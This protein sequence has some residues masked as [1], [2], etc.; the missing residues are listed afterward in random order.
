M[1]DTYPVFIGSLPGDIT[2]EEIDNL[3]NSYG[4]KNYK[5]KKKDKKFRKRFVVLIFFS[6]EDYKAILGMEIRYRGYDLKIMP[7][8]SGDQKKNLDE[9]IKSRRIYFTT[10]FRGLN[11]SLIERIF[12]RYGKLESA[13]MKKGF[14]NAKFRYGFVTYADKEEA[15]KLVEKEVFLYKGVEFLVKPFRQSRIYDSVRRKMEKEQRN[16]QRMS[17]GAH[18]RLGDQ[19]YSRNIA[20]NR[21]NR[22]PKNNRN[23]SD[24]NEYSTFMF[25]KKKTPSHH[26]GPFGA[27]MENL[28]Y[29]YGQGTTQNQ[30]NF[31]SNPKSN[32]TGAQPGFQ[33]F[34][35]HTS[36]HGG[37]YVLGYDQL[38]SFNFTSPQAPDQQDQGGSQR[39]EYREQLN[40]NPRSR[41]QSQAPLQ[42][43][44][45]TL[46][47][48]Q[49][50]NS[51]YFTDPPNSYQNEPDETWIANRPQ[52]EFPQGGLN[53]SIEAWNQ[54]QQNFNY[55][56]TRQIQESQSNFFNQNKIDESKGVFRNEAQGFYS[57][58]PQSNQ[59]G[60]NRLHNEPFGLR[61]GATNLNT[62]EESYIA[63]Q[64]Q[65]R[66]LRPLAESSESNRMVSVQ[67]VGDLRESPLGV[68]HQEQGMRTESQE[69]SRIPDLFCDREGK[70]IAELFRKLSK[71]SVPYQHEFDNV[72][73]NI[74]E[75]KN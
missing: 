39:F 59:Q 34:G 8:L 6:E 7:Y 75:K 72:E 16:R 13:Y 20:T 63:N 42:G 61:A 28:A 23:Q 41:L 17:E 68:N 27:E 57:R 54:N 33:N 47:T 43:Q 24:Q 69:P 64:G 74:F 37:Q 4:F 73:F 29:T 62:V 26:Q 48:K 10:T 32:F 12:S 40:Q 5:F 55:P 21:Q 30:F 2:V 31:G 3:M 35:S 67:A 60:A 22:R 66:E 70:R 71:K 49:N 50:P 65:A 44:Q 56:T 46:K 38:M 9:T 14:E 18:G 45:F 11:N 36:D 52:V 58:S 51:K 25:R 19:F 1:E 15:Q 53:P